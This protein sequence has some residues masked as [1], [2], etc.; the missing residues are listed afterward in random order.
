MSIFNRALSAAEIK[1]LVKNNLH[2]T[3]I[4]DLTSTSVQERTNGYNP[5]ARYFPLDVNGKDEYNQISP[6]TETNIVYD[7]AAYVG[8]GT[9]NL[10]YDSGVIN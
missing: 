8:N 10:V 4:G 3:A 9:T 1:T 5:T 2:I 6:G 7:G